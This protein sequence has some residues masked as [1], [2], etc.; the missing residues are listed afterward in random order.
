MINVHQNLRSK[1]QNHKITQKKQFQNNNANFRKLF[2][3]ALR[4][5][6]MNQKNKE[7]NNITNDHFIVKNARRRRCNDAK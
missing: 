3:A 4:N 1:K 2:E 6:E 5:C 7:K